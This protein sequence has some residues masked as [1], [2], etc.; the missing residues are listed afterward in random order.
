MNIHVVMEYLNT[1]L[2]KIIKKFLLSAGDIKQIMRMILLGVEYIHS[3]FVVHRDI[4]PQVRGAHMRVV[5]CC[6]LRLRFAVPDL[7]FF[8]FGGQTIS[9]RREVLVSVCVSVCACGLSVRRTC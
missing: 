4:K 9:N 5:L 3:R 2:E 6:C 7:Y 1:D 8:S